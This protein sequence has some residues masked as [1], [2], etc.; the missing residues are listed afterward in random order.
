MRFQHLALRLEERDLRVELRADI[1]QRAIDGRLVRHVL[2]RGEDREVIEAG[3]HLAGQRIEMRDLLH[4]VAEEGDAIGGLERRRLHLDHVAADAEPAPA[5]ERV[6]ALVLDVD[7]L[8]QHDVPVDLLPDGEE[9]GLLLVLSRRAEA[10]DARNGGHDDRVSTKQQ[11]ARGRVP[12]AVDVVVDRGVLLD[13]EVG[14]R[15]VRL[16]LVVVVVR[17]EVLDR[18]VREELPELVA[19]LRGERLVVRNHERGLLNL[20]DDPGHRRRLSRSRR[21]E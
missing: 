4:L 17:D 19:E 13:V 12:Q 18:V 14:L 9:H 20:L 8:P 7:Q 16:G 3:Q 11:G 5:E 6:V 21:A 2:R 1:V 15:N 10:V